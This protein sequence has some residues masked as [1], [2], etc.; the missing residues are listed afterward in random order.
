MQLVFILSLSPHVWLRQRIHALEDWCRDQRSNLHPSQKLER[1]F[2]SM[3]R[4]QVCFYLSSI[5][6]YYGI[7]ILKHQVV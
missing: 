1:R 5:S 7:C 2:R 4:L 6:D 3:S